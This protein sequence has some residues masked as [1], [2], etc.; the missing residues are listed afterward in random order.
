MNCTPNDIDVTISDAI[1][2]ANCCCGRHIIP[3]Q[4][5]FCH[6][7]T[8]DAVFILWKPYM[9]RSSAEK[10][11]RNAVARVEHNP[12]FG[13]SFWSYSGKAHRNSILVIAAQPADNMITAWRLTA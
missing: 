5:N 7:N 8:R 4:N 10:M 3:Q 1:L 13:V 9:Y 11:P 2:S 12:G 6:G